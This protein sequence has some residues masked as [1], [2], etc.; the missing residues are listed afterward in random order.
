MMNFQMLAIPVMSDA[1]NITP[2][3]HPATNNNSDASPINPAPNPISD[4]ELVHSS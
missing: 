1:S 4:H 3:L 2:A